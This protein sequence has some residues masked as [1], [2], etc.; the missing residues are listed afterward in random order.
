MNGGNVLSNKLLRGRF[1][2]VLY[3]LMIGT[4][5]L[6]LVPMQTLSVAQA[7]STV[8]SVTAADSAYRK[9]VVD[10]EDK[11]ATGR[12]AKSGAI[13]IADYGSFSVWKTT[14]AQ[15]SGL[16]GRQSVQVSSEF[17]TIEL[18]NTG[19]IDTLNNRIPEIANGL[20][21][22]RTNDYQMWMVQF[23]GPVKNEWVTNLQTMGAEIVSYMPSNAYVIWAT[24]ETLNKLEKSVNTNGYLAWTGAYHPSYRLESSLQALR[25][26]SAK[27]MVNVTVQ[28]YKTSLTSSSLK[29]LQA[30]GGQVFKKPG[31]VLNLAN[32]SLQLP[33][34]QL[35][36]VANWPDV[37][38]IE[39]W[40]APRKLDEVQSQILA[41]NVISQGGKIVPSGPGYLAWLAS[42]GFTTTSSTYPLVDVVD[43]GIDNGTATPLHPVFYELGS[44]SNP[45]RLI[46]NANCTPDATP[47][48][49]GGH[50]NLN[51]GIV[52]GYNNLTVE[53]HTS[54]TT[55]LTTVGYN[56]GLGISPYTRLGGTK[57]FTNAGPYNVTACGDTDEGV[58]DKS[59]TSGATM[60]SNSWGANTAGAYDASSQSYDALTRDSSTTTAGIQPMLHVFAAGNAGPGA[61]TVGSPA[62]GKNI[63]SVAAT[64]N[65]RDQGVTDGCATATADSA[66]DLADFSSRGP[67][68]D[69]RIKP[70]ISGP[71]IHVQGPASQDPGYSGNGVCGA[72]PNTNPTGPNRFYPTTTSTPPINQTIYTW[73]SG[74]SHS[75]PAAAGEASLI[76]K[77]YN[78]ILKPGVNPSP[79][80]I[81]G[82]MLNT[83]RYLNGVSTGGN[84]PT[85]NQ[86]W[87]DV[88]LGTLTDGT[89]IYTTDQGTTFS[90]TGNTFIRSGTIVSS[91]KPLRV[92][93]V[94]SDAPGSTTGSA[95]VNNL[96][97]EVTV[98]GQLYRGNNFTGGTS[99]TNTNVDIRNN[100]ESVFL[101]AGISGT[102]QIKVIAANIAGNGVPGNA[103][104]LDQDFAL[105]AYNAQVAPQ[106]A[107][108]LSSVAFSDVQGGNGNGTVDPGETIA[109]NTSATNSGELTAT[110]AVGTIST[111][112][113]GVTIG[114]GT[115]NYGNIAPGQTVTGTVP[116]TFTVGA[117]FTC[118]GFISF[119][120][121]INYNNGSTTTETFSVQVGTFTVGTV[122]NVY[123]STDVPKAIPDFAGG[124]PGRVASVL[125]INAA[126][127]VGTIKVKINVTHTFDGDLT[128]RLVSPAGMTVTLVAR[129]GGAGDNF[130]NTV[131]DDAAT[132]AIATG[133]APFTGSFRPEQPLSTFRSTPISGTWQLIGEDNAAIDTGTITGWSL[134]IAAGGFRCGTAVATSLVASAGSNQ[135]TVVSSTFTTNLQAQVLDDIG[136]PI[137]GATVTFT[138][139]GSGASGTFVGGSTVATATTN[140]QG[141]A[142]APAFTA[143]GTLGTYNVV[144]T[145][146]GI[147]NGV[148][149]S[150]TNRVGPAAVATPTGSGQSTVIS[151]S[152][153]TA[154]S[155][156]VTDQ[157]GNP[158][159]N[160]QVVFTGPGTG[161][162]GTFTGT[163]SAIFTA[164]TNAQGVATAPTFVANGTTGS[165]TVV[166][167]V[168]GT[169]VFATFNLTNLSSC[170]ANLVTSTSDDGVGTS[171]GTLSF[172]LRNATSGSVISFNV[173]GTGNMTMTINVTGQLPTVPAGV[174]INGGRCGA[175]VLDGTGAGT[176]ANGLVLTGQNTLSNIT[177]QGF[178]GRQLVSNGTRGNRFGPCVI[179]RE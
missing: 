89:P 23:G 143:N 111:T 45:D 27:E 56:R 177:I 163:T 146:T 179:V 11:E 120:E 105:V 48:A 95:F 126:G 10:N 100:V 81:K 51:L 25:A 174:T 40:A 85:N 156:T 178:P 99:N 50:G 5:L 124:V 30:L 158:I 135:S 87:G 130:L 150:L 6:G 55:S 3:V 16:I 104:N 108:A 94:W 169:S 33:V 17:D 121:V 165:Y 92:T 63:I 173:T 2:R 29:E 134:D 7:A 69:G 117:N 39:P 136:S 171:C 151:T 131:L 125:P 113:P 132:A 64:E 101:P 175:V 118:G 166:A 60:T 8:S 129:R 152:F 24:G 14:E 176:G 12:L 148:N 98:N 164:T 65:V 52:G 96:N 15:A 116:F 44:T 168:A 46:Y 70:E 170:T 28:F 147:A 91:T 80:M 18:R 4:L 26:T 43:D 138:A 137:Q 84:L 21:Q 139:P 31:G 162:S 62:T 54:V 161:A 13:L 153:G 53:P 38:N 67:A 19:K 22:V 79:A 32:I 77:Y 75:T 103:S 159:S 157:F 167:N 37:F 128:F 88:N 71:G 35:A 61:S 20:A 115:V 106:A 47:N 127:F 160:T 76:Y 172:A 68:A 57:I 112:V 82:L 90:S 1:A 149:F 59:F 42:K 110:N 86:G 154:L 9:I 58:V 34:S 122:S 107:V 140:A 144:A 93:L 83:A 78:S 142:T 119:T 145:A 141:I 155:V 114:N 74:T 41:G 66:D 102:V 123:T 72:N 109:I 49:I 97:L 133:T 36:K 73:S